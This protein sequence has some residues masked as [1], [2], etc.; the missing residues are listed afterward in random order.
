MPLVSQADAR[1][2]FLDAL[3]GGE[4]EPPAHRR[5]G[6]NVLCGGGRF[7]DLSRFPNWAGVDGPAGRSHAA[8]RYQFEPATWNECAVRLKLKD[9]RM[10]YQDAAA[11]DLAGR[12]YYRHCARSLGSD[13]MGLRLGDIQPALA[14]TWPS[15]NRL[16]LHRLVDE[17]HRV[18]LG[19]T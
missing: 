12:I 9:F 7:S 13:L 15:V 6:Y 2:A 1:Q 8:G 4:S 5:E 18:D 16:F 11:W 10:E 14:S 3:A 17:L 19:Q